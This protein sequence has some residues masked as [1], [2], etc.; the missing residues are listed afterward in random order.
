VT[1]R[2]VRDEPVVRLGSVFK[3]FGGR[4]VLRDVG[5][6]IEPGEVHGL[7]GQ[8]GSGKSTLVK[9]LSGHYAPDP[10]TGVLDVRGQR[11][12]LPLTPPRAQELGLAFVHQELP[13]AASATVLENLRIGRFLSGFGWRIDWRAERRRA[14]ASLR[15]FGL[16]V[17]PEAPVGTL[18][19]V[20]RAMLAILRALEG[21]RDDQPGLIVLDEPTACLPRDGVNRV[22]DAVRAVAS[23]GHGVLLVTHRL[24]ELFAL[25]DRVSVLRDGNVVASLATAATT[26]AE[27]VQ[28]T[29]GFALGE[30]Y[31]SPAEEIGEPVLRVHDLQGEQL[32]SLDLV[33]RAGEVVGLTGLAGAGHEEIPYLLFGARKG[34]GGT[35]TVGTTSLPQARWRPEDAVA[36]GV[37]LL[38]AD[39]RGASCVLDA[40]VQENVTLPTLHR[41]TRGSLVRSRQERSHV[42]RLLN[43]YAVQPAEPGR[44]FGT[45]SG[46]NQQKALL[47][48]WFDL[49]PRVIILHEPTQGVDITSRKTIF[50][51]IRDAAAD[52]VAVIIASTEYED[53]AHLCT[54]VL[55]FR[56]GR[57]GS[58]LRG[59]GLTEARIVEQSMLDEN[60]LEAS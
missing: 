17:D 49:G 47:A 51:H 34:R 1:A 35:V 58:T 32:A 11:V 31:P 20:E 6:E 2:A 13:T 16:D 19:G 43:R 23:A 54:R 40:S 33:V 15:D 44:R 38:P 36:A 48:K 10:G 37:A 52:G 21:L 57:L 7:L 46:G 12:E 60:T 9:I 4:A 25:T 56:S 41:Y 3:S 42:Q 59:A 22:F 28:A 29:V 50:R 53:L 8:N 30:L 39:R 26:Q 18:S 45:L 24:A 27:L 5:L 55:V 14:V